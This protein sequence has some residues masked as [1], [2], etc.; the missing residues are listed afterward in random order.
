M[1]VNIDDGGNIKTDL[2]KKSMAMNEYLMPTSF[3]PK[4]ITD[5]I[6]Y[7]VGLRIRRIC[8][9]EKDFK[10]RVDRLVFTTFFSFKLNA[11]YVY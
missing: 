3:H 1:K 8:S 5:N 2:Y 9:K 7:N 4:H 10:L 11:S 6:P